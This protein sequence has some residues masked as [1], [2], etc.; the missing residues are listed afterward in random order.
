M[1][2][3]IRVYH[4]REGH[5]R[6]AIKHVSDVYN[7]ECVYS[8]SM[9]FMNYIDAPPGVH[10]NDYAEILGH[11]HLHRAIRETT[12]GDEWS[13]RSTKADDLVSMAV[14]KKER[15]HPDGEFTV[16]TFYLVTDG[17]FEMLESFPR[18]KMLGLPKLGTSGVKIDL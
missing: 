3:V 1:K 2:V 16:E 5:T 7:W 12:Q 10:V 9:S 6:P 18:E 11:E 14:T 4:L 17:R 13:R 15:S 8:T